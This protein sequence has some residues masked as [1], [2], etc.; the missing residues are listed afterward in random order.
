LLIWWTNDDSN[1]FLQIY[2]FWRGHAGGANSAARVSPPTQLSRGE[3]ILELT[4][5]LQIEISLSANTNKSNH[6]LDFIFGIG[7]SKNS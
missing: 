7:C 3:P 6:V 1:S 4:L 2:R 5:E